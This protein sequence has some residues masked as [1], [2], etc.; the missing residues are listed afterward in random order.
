[1]ILAERF[2]VAKETAARAHAWLAQ[3]GYV[4][5]VPGVGMLVTPPERWKPDKHPNYRRARP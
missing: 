5:T 4:V 2:G 1:V 3:H